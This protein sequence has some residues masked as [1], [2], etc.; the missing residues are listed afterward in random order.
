ML[1]RFNSGKKNVNAHF[2]FLALASLRD[3]DF[4]FSSGRHLCS[5]LVH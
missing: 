2:F 3:Y 1:H 5:G 4:D